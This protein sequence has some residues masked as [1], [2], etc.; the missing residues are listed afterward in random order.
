MNMKYYCGI[1]TNTMHLNNPPPP[2][3]SGNLAGVYFSDNLDSAGFY[4]SD[5]IWADFIFSQKK[6][7]DFTI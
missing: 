1:D 3:I 5:A 2:G 6:C 4:F 7:N